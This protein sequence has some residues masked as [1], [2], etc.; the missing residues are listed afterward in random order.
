MT[1]QAK[2]DVICIGELLIDFLL[3]QSGV[4]FE[5]VREFRKVPGGAPANVAVGIS[6]LGMTSAFV[7]RVGDDRFGRYLA[8]V[9]KKNGVDISQLQYDSEARTTLAFISL[10]TPNTRE[11]LFY[12]NPG[13][14]MN[15]DYRELK[16]GFMD[17]TRIC[18]FGSITL[19]NE[20][21]RT[22]T[23]K[24][25]EMVKSAGSLI[26]YDPNFRPMLWPSIK[27]AKEIIGH[28]AT[29]ADIIKVS[30]EELELIS[31]TVD[32]EKG[33]KTI[34][35]MGPRICMVTMGEKGCYY[36]TGDFAGYLPAYRVNTVDATG[37]GDSFVSGVLFEIAANGI[38]ELLKKE[39]SLVEAVKF[40]SAAAALTAMKKGVIPALPT[41]VE[42]NNYISSSKSQ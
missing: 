20:P 15:L 5:K 28:A 18:H 27:Q 25:V 3:L 1:K 33:S 4:R 24:A 12:R 37:C 42:V 34:L 40:A 39:I 22:S 13:A 2:M 30:N 35:D 19:I 17:N 9:L 32:F 21:S 10:P 36:A 7:G 29:L 16:K 8:A 31:G 41:R 11:F 6:R 38:K 14:D 23:Y 26:S